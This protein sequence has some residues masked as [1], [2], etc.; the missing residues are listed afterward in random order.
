MT[1]DGMDIFVVDE[2]A[3]RVTGDWAIADFLD[4]LMQASA[5]ELATR[6]TT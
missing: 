1:L 5:V 6:S 2:E 3:E 4:L